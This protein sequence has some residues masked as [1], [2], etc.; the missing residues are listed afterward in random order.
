MAA[1]PVAANTSANLAI[2]AMMRLKMGATS[3]LDP[4]IASA[5]INGSGSRMTP[6]REDNGEDGKKLTHMTKGRAR[7]PKRRLPKA[8]TLPLDNL[9]SPVI[10]AKP[11][12]FAE[13]SNDHEIAS[14]SGISDKP[15][16]TRS[17]SYPSKRND[18]FSSVRD[19]MAL[20]TNSDSQASEL[21]E[22]K[23]NAQS[24]S[25]LA[26]S[27]PS[28]P[29]KP[30][31]VS[32]KLGDKPRRFFDP[33]S[34]DDDSGMPLIVRA[35]PRMDFSK[36]ATRRFNMSKLDERREIAKN[37]VVPDKEAPGH[38]ESKLILRPEPLENESLSNNDVSLSISQSDSSALELEGNPT[39][40]ETPGKTNSRISVRESD[41]VASSVPFLSSKPAGLIQISK[42][43]DRPLLTSQVSLDD[44]TPQKS[45][46]TPSDVSMFSESSP[47]NQSA[48]RDIFEQHSS[49][50]TP[51]N[52]SAKPKLR[53]EPKR[54][55]IS[56]KTFKE[57]ETQ[58]R[59]RD[60]QDELLVKTVKLD[61]ANYSETAPRPAAIP[62]RIKEVSKEKSADLLPTLPSKPVKSSFSRESSTVPSLPSKPTFAAGREANPSISLKSGID[63]N[64]VEALLPARKEKFSP[65]SFV[66]K[67]VY[68]DISN[69][70]RSLKRLDRSSEE[71]Q[72]AKSV[73]IKDRVSKLNGN[74]ASSKASLSPKLTPKPNKPVLSSSTP[75]LSPKPSPGS[76]KSPHPSLTP[77][78]RAA[79]KVKEDAPTLSPKPTLNASRSKVNGPSR[80]TTDEPDIMLLFNRP[81][82]TSTAALASRFEAVDAAASRPNSTLSVKPR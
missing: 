57:S 66:S 4:K 40:V 14:S 24:S 2:A 6:S 43:Y 73:N 39:K 54:F 69:N 18:G 68:D 31:F 53:T 67:Q 29:R 26:P 79:A 58:G 7:G 77:R 48:L 33:I 25:R 74:P 61:L 10:P 62:N 44:V 52:I 50:T 35:S 75:V 60:T 51:P 15:P 38:I 5:I 59:T 65:R 70:H 47:I 30:E 49:K 12:Y 21:V 63:K 11:N 23:N 42:S 46:S 28:L 17:K 9:S 32:T 72:E 41:E 16:I 34:D 3:E 64:S 20:F 55:D 19:R 71:A 37:K 8:S 22:R 1:G 78:P 36:P 56:S 27:G 76:F 80:T 81:T 45:T 13:T 82:S